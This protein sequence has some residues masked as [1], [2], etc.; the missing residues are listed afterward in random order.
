MKFLVSYTTWFQDW[1]VPWYWLSLSLLLFILGLIGTHPISIDREQDPSIME[2]FLIKVRHFSFAL[3]L[4]LIIVMPLTVWAAGVT[5]Y[6]QNKDQFTSSFIDFMLSGF[7]SVWEF[8]IIGM[9]FGIIISFTYHRYVL[10]KVSAFK[11]RFAVKQ[12]GEELSDIR[13]EEGQVATR[14]FKPEKYYKEGQ[15]FFGLDQQNKPIY[16]P[17]SLWNTR[18][19]R[20]VGPTQTGKGVEIGLQLDQSIRKGDT[21]IFIDPKPDKHAKAIMKRAA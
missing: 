8:P 14:N 3:I 16:E 18:H 17:V 4:F 6:S 11:R 13:A 15:I 1:S 19:I 5:I 7:M 9:L 10:I 21:T 20:A 12:S 2:M